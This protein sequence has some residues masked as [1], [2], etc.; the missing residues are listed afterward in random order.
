M[1]KPV[2]DRVEIERKEEGEGRRERERERENGQKL[3]LGIRLNSEASLPFVPSL[4]EREFFSQNGNRYC[5]SS[6][7]GGQC[8]QSKKSPNIN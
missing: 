1:N 4:T 6:S 2:V 8:D 3:I 5:S 7:V